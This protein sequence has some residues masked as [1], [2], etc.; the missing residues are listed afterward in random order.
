MGDLGCVISQPDHCV[1]HPQGFQEKI[2]FSQAL[3]Q[4][5]G[6]VQFAGEKETS[7]A[8]CS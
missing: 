7:R 8:I 6:K 4:A 2:R 5:R 1:G 3:L